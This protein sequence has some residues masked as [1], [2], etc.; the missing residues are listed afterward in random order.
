MPA[1]ERRLD[2]GAPEALES[3]VL[4]ELSIFDVDGPGH[5]ASDAWRNG[6]EVKIARL[7]EA[8][9]GLYIY[10]SRGGYRIVGRL[11]QTFMIK[12]NADAIAWTAGYLSWIAYL[13]RV[14]GIEADIAC[15]DW[16]HLFRLPHATRE[17]GG[18]PEQLDTVG[19]PH[20]VGLWDPDITPEDEKA[21]RLKAKPKGQASGRDGNK[22]TEATLASQAGGILDGERN[23]RLTSIAGSLRRQGLSADSIAEVLGAL[24]ARE[25][26]P[27]LDDSE[28]GTIAKSIG[29]YPTEGG[30]RDERG[31]G[32]YTASAA[33]LFRQR[34]DSN[35]AELDPVALANFTATIRGQVVEDDG[36]EQRQAF[37]IEANLDGRSH[38]FR[39]PAERFHAMN[40][41]I[42]RLGAAAIVFP[43]Q[44]NRDHVRAAIRSFRAWKRIADRT[45]Y[46]HVGWREVNGEAVYLLR[47]PLQTGHRFQ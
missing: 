28:V 13:R 44:T 21:G 18:S 23:K 26:I 5:Q 29:G 15:K 16:Q 37:E 1:K 2:Q 20:N 22:I 43:G 38:A 27:P 11:P 40:W 36:A 6:E 25:C 32:I 9:P 33:G 30:V 31:A 42:E 17:K 41:P 24:N 4:M 14:F 3:G 34:Y 8:H 19:D 10:H 45:V 46:R 12:S 47:I 35:G 39:I 7:F